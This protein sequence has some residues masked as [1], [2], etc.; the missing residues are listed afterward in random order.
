M[1]AIKELIESE[2]GGIELLLGSESNGFRS[3]K[4]QVS[5]P[6]GGRNQLKSTA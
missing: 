5:L 4:L 2:G 1:N 6:L 3:F